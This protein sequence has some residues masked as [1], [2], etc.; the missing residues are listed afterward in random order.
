MILSHF[1]QN[2]R[3]IRSLLTHL[4][5][6]IL[7]TVGAPS[8]NPSTHTHTSKNKDMSVCVLGDI[9]HS[10]IKI[11]YSVFTRYKYA[12]LYSKSSGA[13]SSVSVL[14]RS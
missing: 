2:W 4:G 9:L 7:P 3:E 1:G 11:D 13:E 12:F 10:G 5:F 6:I 8:C 14:D